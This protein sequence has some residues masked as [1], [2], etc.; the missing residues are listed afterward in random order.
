MGVGYINFIA[1]CVTADTKLK[2]LHLGAVTFENTEDIDLLCA[3]V[4]NH[5]SLQRLVV[6]NC[7]TDQGGL[8][9]IFNKLKSQTLEEIDLLGNGISNLNPGDMSDFLS[10]NPSLRKLNL[11]L[12]PFN[13]QDIV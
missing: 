2:C 9:E 5:D 3:A 13:E 11:V 4:N 12:N 8:R 10:S 6:R 7:D 1:N